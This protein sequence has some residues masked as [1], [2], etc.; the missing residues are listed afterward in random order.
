MSIII[1]AHVPDPRTP[2]HVSTNVV[3]V[4][5]DRDAADELVERLSRSDGGGVRYHLAEAA[6]VLPVVSV[7]SV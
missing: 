1:I 3:G 6:E 5:D 7:E 2:G 4:A